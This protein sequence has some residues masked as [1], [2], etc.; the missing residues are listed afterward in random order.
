MSILNWGFL[1]N[2]LLTLSLYR[3]VT[4]SSG[5]SYWS[6]GPWGCPHCW[7]FSTAAVKLPSR[8]WITRSRRKSSTD[9]TDKTRDLRIGITALHLCTSQIT[10]CMHFIFY[11]HMCPILNMTWWH[12]I[13]LVFL[14]MFLYFYWYCRGVQATGH[15]IG[16]LYIKLWLWRWSLWE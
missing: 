11:T 16:K 14:I 9:V 5:E 3:L 8:L 1:C 10:I 2:G 7:H 15:T 13:I 12:Y 6:P 4:S